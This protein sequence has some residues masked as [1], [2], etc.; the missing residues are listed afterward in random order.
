MDQPQS[1]VIRLHPNAAVREREDGVWFQSDSPVVFQHA[2]ISTMSELEAVFLYNLGGRFMQIRKVMYHYMQRQ[3]DGRFVHLLVWLFND[4]HVRVTIGFHCRLMPQHVMDFL[5]DVGR[6]PAGQSVTAAPVRIAEPP[7]RKQKRPWVIQRR[8]IRTML[9][10]LL[11][12]RTL[13]KALDLDEGAC[14]DLLNAGMGNDY[15][16]D[17]GQRFDS[18]IGCATGKRSRLQ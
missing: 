7:R 13:R 1:L 14:S 4:E 15:N 16:T 10:A 3:P 9:R 11:H 6:I 8:M 18:A 5:V 2:D 12:P 17:G